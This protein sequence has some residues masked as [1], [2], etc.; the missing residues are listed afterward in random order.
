MPETFDYSTPGSE[1]VT[2]LNALIN[3]ET[4]YTEDTHSRN[5]EILKSIINN[6]E[7]T[8]AP[9]S[10]IEELLLELKEK[11][12]GEVEIDE[13][14]VT[15]NGTYSETGKAYS[16]VN[17][18]VQPELITKTITANGTYNA[19][20][21][22]ADGYSSVTVAVEGYAKKS[23]QNTPTPIATFNASA[24]PMPSLNVGIEAVQSGSGDPSPTNVRPISGWSAVK[25]Y[26]LD[27][28]DKS[29]F[30]KG[31]TN[32]TFGYVD[33]GTL[34][35]YKS[36]EIN[37]YAQLPQ[38]KVVEGNTPI[39]AISTNGMIFLQMIG[40]GNVE[41]IAINDSAYESYT[42][43]QFKTAMSGVYLIYELATPT[44]PTITDTQFNSLLTAFGV[45]GTTYTTALKD[46]Q[47]N[48]MTCYGGTLS[49]VNGVQT[50]ANTGVNYTLS[51]V[52][53]LAVGNLPDNNYFYKTIGAY[54]YADTTKPIMCDKFPTVLLNVS[55]TLVGINVINS[56]AYNEARIIFRPENVASYNVE[57]INTWLASN[58]LHIKF[59]KATPQQIP[60]DNLPIATQEGT[61]N[62]WADSGDVLSGEYLEAL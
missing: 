20:S 5:A 4:P 49:N 41:Y 15:E 45:N 54:G 36:G 58:P 29:P 55:N 28:T 11:I 16:P 42:A 9:Q 46:G 48:P 12:G 56:Q 47:G 10:E 40:S 2:L 43:A 51:S 35:W 14:N 27:N 60:Q 52:D 32:G 8:D 1:N 62:L 25:E 18:N 53:G 17:V 21:D 59:E 23:I 6:T 33:L 38:H 50:L 57:T 30:F 7:Y 24:L 26:N 39:N 44:T 37:F 19:S 22:D 61:N 34:R 31:L 13:L 3:D